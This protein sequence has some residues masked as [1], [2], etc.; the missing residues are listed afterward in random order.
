[1]LLEINNPKPVPP[2]SDFDANFLNSLGNISGC[3]P[4]PVSLTLT[5]TDLSLFL[6]T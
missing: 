2:V 6:P 5:I 4:V 1:M 3:I